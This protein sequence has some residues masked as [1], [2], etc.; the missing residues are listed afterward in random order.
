[1]ML[2]PLGS[3]LLLVSLVWLCLLLHG[4]W[5]SDHA[6]MQPILPHR[7]LAVRQHTVSWRQAL[8]ASNLMS[9]KSTA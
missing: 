7:T 3:L 9:V 6:T 8:H 5:P 2:D 1:M 4:A